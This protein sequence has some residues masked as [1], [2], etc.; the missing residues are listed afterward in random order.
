MSKELKIGGNFGKDF[1]QIYV[2]DEPTNIFI[3]NEG[4]IK[5]A[6]FDS[7]VDGS[8]KIKSDSKI[9]FRDDSRSE[10]IL[11]RFHY[12]VKNIAFNASV[13]FNYLPINGYV[14]ERTTTSSNNEFIAM[15]APYDCIVD[16]FAFRS[17]FAQSGNVRFEIHESEDGT[18]VPGTIIFRQNATVSLAD[19]IYTNLSL[20]SPSIGTF[21]PTLTKGNIY[22]FSFNTPAAP[23]D[24]NFSMVFKWDVLS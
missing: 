11:E 21:P 20:D 9:R 13:T 7:D 1:Q 6:N 10:Q 18:E 4:K 15:I 2:G 8:V 5:S 14:V 16:T 3:N 22:A 17:E 23:G 19:D 24:I 12:Q